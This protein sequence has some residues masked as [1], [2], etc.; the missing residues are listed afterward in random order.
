[1]RS[2]ESSE[3]KSES[4]SDAKNGGGE[5]KSVSRARGGKRGEQPRLMASVDDAK[6]SVESM[7]ETVRTELD[8]RPWRTLGLAVG[9]GYILGGGLLTPLTFRLLT[10][11]VKIGVRV[12]ALPIVGEE[13]KGFVET[14]TDG[15]RG[16]PQR[17]QQ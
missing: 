17:R 12:A 5:A 15:G 3:G 11:A 7:I 1:M 14:F 8:E 16:E 10:S 13:I 6:Q 4:K 2:E 9:A